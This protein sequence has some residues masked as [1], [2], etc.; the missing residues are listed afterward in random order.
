MKSLILVGLLVFCGLHS[1]EATINIDCYSEVISCTYSK[2]ASS[3]C[4]ILVN[5]Q[6]STTCDLETY[7]LEFVNNS[8]LPWVDTSYIDVHILLVVDCVTDNKDECIRDALEDNEEQYTC[9]AIST[10]FGDTLT[11]D[12]QCDVPQFSHE[13]LYMKLYKQLSTCS[14]DAI[15]ILVQ[16]C[17][18]IIIYY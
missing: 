3:S 8:P 9:M 14:Y 2:N 13:G 10:Q 6:E 7:T 5:S 18:C 16:D 1:A 12:F 17:K 11:V 15:L 4:S